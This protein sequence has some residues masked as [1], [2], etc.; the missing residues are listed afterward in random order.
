MEPYLFGNFVYISGTKQTITGIN[1]IDIRWKFY[2]SFWSHV[3]IYLF[4]NQFS[5][6]FIY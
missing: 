1:Y 5:H 4:I 6:S 3:P 2:L